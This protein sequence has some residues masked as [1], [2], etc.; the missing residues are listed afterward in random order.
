[1]TK[2]SNITLTPTRDLRPL[3]PSESTV[4]H[5]VMLSAISPTLFLFVISPRQILEAK[6]F[7]LSKTKTNYLECKFSDATQNVGIEVRLDT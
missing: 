7:R 3:L 6:G 4:G 5:Q 2:I 1:M